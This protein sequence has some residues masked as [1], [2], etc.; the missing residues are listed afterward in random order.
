MLIA[1]QIYHSNIKSKG[2]PQPFKISYFFNLLWL[3][4]LFYWQCLLLSCNHLVKPCFFPT[5]VLAQ[6]QSWPRFSPVNS[7]IIVG[8]GAAL[9]VCLAPFF[10]PSLHC[11]SRIRPLQ[12]MDISQTTAST[13]T[14]VATN[15]TACMS[16]IGHNQ[17]YFC[18]NYVT[19]N[20]W[21]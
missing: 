11:Q 12:R 4:L 9:S 6:H 14:A 5:V 10:L 7:Y 1:N 17:Y 18:Y 16:V 15:T 13:T 8:S 20:N 2:G 3:L 21:E 19:F